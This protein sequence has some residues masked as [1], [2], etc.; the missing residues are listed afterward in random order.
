MQ[1]EIF[2]GVLPAVE[3][4]LNRNES[5]Y[6]QSGGLAWMTDGFKMETNTRGGFL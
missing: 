4:T 5:V 2:G 1:Y 6:T 3:L